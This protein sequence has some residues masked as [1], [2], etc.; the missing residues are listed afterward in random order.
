VIE[1]VDTQETPGS[2]PPS[3][4]PPGAAGELRVRAARLGNAARAVLRSPP[5]MAGAVMIV[6]LLLMA[7][8]APLLV[9]SNS[10]DPYQMPR[11]WGA[12]NQPPGSPGHLLGTDPTGGDVLYGI[13]WGSRTSLRLAVTVVAAS[14]AIGTAI[15]SLAGFLGGWV[16][17]VLMR[18]VDVVLAVPKMILALAIAGLLGPSFTNIM[19]ALILSS[20][21]WYARLV[22]GEIL[23][24]KHEEYVDAA[25]ALGDSGWRI[26]W[27]DVLPNSLTPATVYATLE[28]GNVVIIGATLSFIG[29]A[30]A[31]LAEWGVLVSVG[32]DVLLGGRWWTSTFAGAMVF[33]WALSF[34]LVGDGLRD[35]LDPRMELG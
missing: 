28:M 20:W 33:I 11:D 26:Y 8:L 34:N 2:L 5:T 7:A 10:P 32:Q 12:L 4:G 29:L 15:G 23:R 21:T 24:V 3:Q 13:V 16:D 1:M 27:K 22:R 35:I 19:I 6:L 17:G 18:F 31:G 9:G 30:E 14:M 25:R